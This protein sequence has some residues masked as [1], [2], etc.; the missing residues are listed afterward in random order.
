[1]KDELKKVGWSA[2]GATG[3]PGVPAVVDQATWQAELDALRVQ[4][5]AHTREGD[6][7]AAAR[8][9]LPMVAVDPAIPLIGEHGPVT[10][11]E[12]FEGRAADRLLSHMVRWPARRRPVRGLHVLQRAGPRAVL[13]AFPRRHLRHV[14]PGPLQPLFVGSY[15]VV[16]ALAGVVVYAVYQPHGTLAAGAVA[17]AAGAYEFTPL[18]QH[19]RRRC[20]DNTGSGLGFGLCCAGSSMG[21]MAML[22]ALGAMSITWRTVITVLA[23]A[24]KLLPP[25]ATIDV[26]LALAIIGLGIWIVIAPASVPGLMPPI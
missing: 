25:R 19:C 4:E 21:L 6:A 13:P 9:R 15:L 17:I 10:L 8:R 11:L 18:K 22:V 23:C 12:V 3:T 1:M 16:W 2:A 7:I 26:P 24:Q 14:L 5:K 20:R